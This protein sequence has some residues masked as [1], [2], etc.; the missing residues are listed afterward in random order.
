MN[1]QQQALDTASVWLGHAVHDSWASGQRLDAWVNDYTGFG[2][3]RDKTEHGYVMA[4]LDLSDYALDAL[5]HDDDI[6]QVMI[7][8]YPQEALRKGYYL[9]VGDPH[10]KKQEA[11][12][13]NA[14]DELC[15]NEKMIEGAIWGDLYGGSGM[16][17]GA[18]DGRPAH[19]PL[20]PERV[21][22]V[23]QVEVL[24]R[25]YLSVHSR[26]MSG[27]KTGRAESYAVGNPSGV[28][29]PMY[30]VHESRMIMFGGA[31]TAR[32]RQEARGG[33]DQSKL[34]RPFEVI[35]KFATGFKAVETLLTDGPQGVYK[36]KNL[37]NLLASSKQ[38][39]LKDRIE[40]VEMMR[41][42]MRAIVVDTEN[43]DFTRQ[44]FSFAGIPDVLDKLMLRLSAA[45]G[46][47][48]TLLMGQS[49]AGMNA[50][51][52]SDF[53]GFYGKVETYQHNYIRPRL[54]R[55][56][57][58]LCAAKEGPTKGKVPDQIEI[59]FQKLW[60]LDPL[61][62]AQRRSAIATTDKIYVDMGAA[63]PEEIALS[64]FGER[65]YEDGYKIDRDLR[66]AALEEADDDAP[67]PNALTPSANEAVLSVNEARGMLGQGDDP[68]PEFG[69]LK[70]TA[71]KAQL[72][73]QASVEGEA[74]GKENTGQP[75]VEPPPVAPGFGGPP[76][77]PGQGPNDRHADPD[78]AGFPGKAAP[79]QAP[80][81]KGA[82]VPA[83]NAPA[84]GAGAGVPK[85][86]S[87][88]KR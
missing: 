53:R 29:R 35:R 52:D 5:Y 46:I 2:T 4:R 22:R 11:E 80:A 43:E 71:A 86:P 40:T 65:G 55:L 10:D 3:S 31:R 60:T 28:A 74:A 83:G 62:E 84:G 81:D 78:K 58:I 59:Q 17:I 70:V 42:A 24:D 88:P 36:I 49:P 54:K 76:G 20:V 14:L 13:L 38:Q 87:K 12:I 39:A 57:E 30:I 85:A 44:P 6:A 8:T 33:W 21:R 41:S 26:Y 32:P 72:E 45:A 1:Q 9:N 69:E 63:T 61:A 34:Q 68:D 7:D 66:M 23:D 77:A 79:K 27:P 82:K 47:P 19:M 48:V 37:S 18:D 64:R 15:A 73:A 51:G 67:P 50:T 75:V 16:L 56:I 25:R